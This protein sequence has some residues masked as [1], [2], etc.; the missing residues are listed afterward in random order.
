MNIRKKSSKIDLWCK[1]MR[2]AKFRFPPNTKC[3]ASLY[4]ALV[5]AQPATMDRLF[6]FSVPRSADRE[7]YWD[8]Y[9]VMSEMKVRDLWP[10]VRL[11]LTLRAAAQV[12]HRKMA[13]VV[14]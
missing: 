1:D 8:L 6:A 4:D 14:C 10:T 7:H 2:I 12:E 5:K 11:V 13:G 3:V 9:S